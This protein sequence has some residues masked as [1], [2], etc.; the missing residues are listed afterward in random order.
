MS[1]PSKLSTGPNHTILQLSPTQNAKLASRSSSQWLATRSSRVQITSLKESSRSN[2][3]LLVLL[4]IDSFHSC[5]D[6][7]SAA[8]KNTAP[9]EHHQVCPCDATLHGLGRSYDT[10]WIDYD[11]FLQR[12]SSCLDCSSNSSPNWESGREEIS[13][14]PRCISNASH[15]RFPNSYARTMSY[16]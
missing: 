11:P 15:D 1:L 6:S 3:T 12:M 14:S 2:I 9:D 10:Y 16:L 8:S 4:H 7:F 5:Q 13:Q